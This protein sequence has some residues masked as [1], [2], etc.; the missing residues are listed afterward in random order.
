[1]NELLHHFFD[2]AP[3]PVAPFSHAEETNGWVFLSGQI[4]QDPAADEP[5]QDA[6][7]FHL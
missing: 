5:E 2:G 4:P 1:M 7:S 3:A 6:F